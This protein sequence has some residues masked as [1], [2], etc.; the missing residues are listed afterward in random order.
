MTPVGDWAASQLSTLKAEQSDSGSSIT[1][2][3]NIIC[4]DFGVQGANVDDTTWIGN[5]FA[6]TT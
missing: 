1:T 2:A 4:I 3:S 6:V 5:V